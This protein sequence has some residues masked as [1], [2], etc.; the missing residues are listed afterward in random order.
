MIVEGKV[1]AHLALAVR[2][3]RKHLERCGVDEPPGIA[4]WYR[5]FVAAAKRGQNGMEGDT[6]W[7]DDLARLHDGRMFYRRREVAALSGQSTKT[8]GRLVAAG[9]LRETEL[10]IPRGELERLISEREEKP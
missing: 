4:D 2:A 5:V 10:G 8:I 9:V 1:S 7:L 3:W 6:S